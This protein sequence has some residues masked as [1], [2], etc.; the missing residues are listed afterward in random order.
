MLGG[1]W[2]FACAYHS[3]SYFLATE[4]SL[5]SQYDQDPSSHTLYWGYLLLGPIEK[6]MESSELLTGLLLFHWRGWGASLFVPDHLSWLLRDYLGMYFRFK[7]EGCFSHGQ[8]RLLSPLAVVSCSLCGVKGSALWVICSRW[9]W[10]WA[11]WHI[12]FICTCTFQSPDDRYIWSYFRGQV[13]L[14]GLTTACG[15]F[16][17]CFV[18][19][20]KL[21][22][23]R[24]LGFFRLPVIHSWLSLFSCVDFLAFIPKIFPGIH[25]AIHGS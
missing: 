12:F 18:F 14:D 25:H 9:K 19:L 21:R 2:S 10:E 22:T 3:T 17:E 7:A 24:A 1:L 20:K 4:I 11:R 16:C 23:Q 8:S 6:A 5:K 13:L 15:T